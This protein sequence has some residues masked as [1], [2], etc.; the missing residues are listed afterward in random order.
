MARCFLSKRAEQDIEE[1]VS[2]IRKD[3]LQDSLKV[4]RA[5]RRT[6]ELVGTMPQIGRKANDI[7]FEELYYFPVKKFGNYLLFYILMDKRPLILRVLH[8]RRDIPMIMKKWYN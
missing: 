4:M 2:Y 6:C 3:S 7:G 8:A 5:I 1:I